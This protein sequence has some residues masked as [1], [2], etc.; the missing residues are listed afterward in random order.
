MSYTLINGAPINGDGGGDIALAPAGIDL[1]N[2]GVHSAVGGTVA[3]DAQP[4]ELGEHSAFFAYQP[5]GLDLVTYEPHIG[6]HDIPLTPPGLDLVTHEPHSIVVAPVAGDAQPLELGDWRLQIGQDIDL[7]PAGLDL[8]RYSFHTAVVGA[9]LPGNGSTIAGNARPMEVGSPALVP[10]AAE[11]TAGAAQPLE[12]GSHAIG[13]ALVA[14]EAQPMEMGAPGPLGYST[15]AGAAQPLQL[16]AHYIG[17]Q[18]T[19]PGLDLLSYGVHQIVTGPTSTVA[20]E[21]QPLELGQPGALGY[22]TITRQAFPLELGSH[23]I[24]RGN[25][26]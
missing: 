22:G 21:A 6:F 9:I 18:I 3:G 23:A 2:A 20:G 17:I 13:V 19:V 24:S 11:T 16:G 25:A 7:T 10:A 15:F 1:L 26:C 8:V 12:L 5:A 14:G 4:L